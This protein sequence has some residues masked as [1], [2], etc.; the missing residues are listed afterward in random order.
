MNMS[1]TC[2]ICGKQ[3]APRPSNAA[4]PFC[5]PRCKQIDLGKW[6]DEGY[7]IPTDEEPSN[8]SLVSSAGSR[9]ETLS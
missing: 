6:L 8:D 9:K 4:A 3:G 1:A 2:P 7:R 5:S